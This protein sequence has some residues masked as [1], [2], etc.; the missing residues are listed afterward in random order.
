M[1]FLG[2]DMS[3]Y[4]GAV[5]LLV[6]GGALYTA[7][8]AASEALGRGSDASSPEIDSA[9]SGSDTWRAVGSWVPVA[10]VVMVATLLGRV[11]VAVGVIFA[12]SVACLSLVPGLAALFQPEGATTEPADASRTPR[13]AWGFVLAVALMLLIIGF[14]GRF[15]LLHAGLLFAQGL[16]IFFLFGTQ[17]ANASTI[18][19]TTSTL[20]PASPFPV[21]VIQLVLAIGVAGVGA[22][23]ATRGMEVITRKTPFFSFATLAAIALA[24]LLTLPMIGMATEFSRRGRPDVPIGSGVTVTLL[25]LC[26]LL[27]LVIVIHAT[28]QQ[29]QLT[30]LTY[31]SQGAT[32]TNSDDTFGRV[33][34]VQSTS[35]PQQTPGDQPTTLPPPTTLPQSTTLPG[36]Q[37]TTRDEPDF[38]TT[39]LSFPLALWRIDTVLL[40]VFGFILL[41]VSTGRWNLGPLEGSVLV[42][43]YAAYVMM[44]ARFGPGWQ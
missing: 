7:A 33:T 19:S 37:T 31:S 15:T 4:V 26:L 42:I 12:V 10:V 6:A 35:A 1:N 27:P 43:V 44:L 21:R 23:V 16:A 28:M 22:Y 14:S 32:V 34:S 5:M 29:Y 24:P 2:Y 20:K 3:G 9:F 39:S 40:V 38:V 13:R 25:N 30:Q 18:P 8:R 17:R 36:T 41:P 11:E